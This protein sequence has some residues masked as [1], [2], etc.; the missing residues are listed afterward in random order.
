MNR[1][2]Q[3]N[4]ALKDQIASLKREKNADKNSHNNELSLLKKEIMIL[5]G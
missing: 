3:E 1:L 2:Q 4:I 5:K